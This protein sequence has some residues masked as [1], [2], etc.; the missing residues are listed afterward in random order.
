MEVVFSTGEVVWEGR[1]QPTLALE[2]WGIWTCMLRFM[3]FFFLEM[4]VW[5][6]MKLRY[7]PR[8]LNSTFNGS[9]GSQSLKCRV[10]SASS[11][12]QS[13]RLKL[14]LLLITHLRALL[15]LHFLGMPL[16]WTWRITEDSA[17]A[18]QCV[19]FEG[20]QYHPCFVWI[21]RRAPTTS[22]ARW[23]CE[24][25]E[26]L[27]GV[28]P[29]PSPRCQMDFGVSSTVRIRW[30]GVE[31]QRSLFWTC[32]HKTQCRK[33]GRDWGGRPMMIALTQLQLLL[34][35]SFYCWV[36]ILQLFVGIQCFSFKFISA[37]LWKSHN[38]WQTQTNPP[39]VF[40]WNRKGVTITES[41]CKWMQHVWLCAKFVQLLKHDKKNGSHFCIS[42]CHTVFPCLAWGLGSINI[43]Q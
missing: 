27:F 18:T 13:L 1:L 32:C 33:G 15:I 31:G 25:L 40:V 22:Q 37:S 29:I 36:D 42:V 24:V 26:R 17:K 30:A 5:K 7:A 21:W 2:R 4:L 28:F 34:F 38:N 9:N 39:L 19:W 10:F 20:V 43:P 11:S 12:P 8:W 14:D 23:W 6:S 3:E 16:L 41:Y 35:L